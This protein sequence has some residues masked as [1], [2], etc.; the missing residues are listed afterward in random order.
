MQSC[1]SVHCL[2]GQRFIS[3][4]VGWANMRPQSHWSRCGGCPDSDAA[5]QDLVWYQDACERTHQLEGEMLDAAS[6][7][8]GMLE[9][10]RESSPAAAKRTAGVFGCSLFVQAGALGCRFTAYAAAT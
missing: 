8:V 1:S 7:L 5:H 4:Q 6:R 2:D 9:A 10:W 3:F